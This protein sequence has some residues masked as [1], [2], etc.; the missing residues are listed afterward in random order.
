[1]H[2][3]E[4]PGQSNFEA[5]EE[6]LSD[7]M[8]LPENLCQV[9]SLAYENKD[10]AR[11]PEPSRHSWAE[12]RFRRSRSTPRE[13]SSFPCGRHVAVSHVWALSGTMGQQ[14]GFQNVV[15][16]TSLDMS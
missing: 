4:V 1:M 13:G 16:W 11:E 8:L 14:P 5:Y 15:K 10:M 9:T 3:S 2:D 6:K 12:L 7:S